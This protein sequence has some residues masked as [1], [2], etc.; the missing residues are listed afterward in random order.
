MRRACSIRVFNVL[1]RTLFETNSR[2]CR[3]E[4]AS[5]TWA[6][7]TGVLLFSPAVVK[8]K[9]Q[10]ILARACGKALFRGLLRGIG[11]L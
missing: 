5:L 7:M 11:P 6:L 8:A 1:L 9:T 3:S 2:T 4:S 10:I